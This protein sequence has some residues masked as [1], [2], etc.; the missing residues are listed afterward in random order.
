[1]AGHI[2]LPVEFKTR[3]VSNTRMMKTPKG[4][5][6]EVTF[7]GSILEWFH[8]RAR[9]PFTDLCAPAGVAY[10]GKDMPSEASMKIKRLK[11]LMT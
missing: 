1:M 5:D 10:T 3:H 4:R 9:C 11:A 2:E 7:Y 8:V 6:A